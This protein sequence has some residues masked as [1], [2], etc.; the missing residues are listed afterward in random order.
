MTEERPLFKNAKC[1]VCGCKMV[2]AD[3][4]KHPL[5]GECLVIEKI[6]KTRQAGVHA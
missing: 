5:C 2:V 4:D 3:S 1:S 6:E